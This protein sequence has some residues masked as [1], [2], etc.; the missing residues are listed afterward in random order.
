MPPLRGQMRTLSRLMR[1]PVWLFTLPA[2][3]SAAA[4]ASALPAGLSALL[5]PAG[6]L[7]P[8]CAV[9]CAVLSAITST[10]T[11]PLRLLS[12]LPCVAC[13][14][15]CALPVVSF[16]ILSPLPFLPPF[17]G[18]LCVFCFVACYGIISL[19]AGRL[20]CDLCL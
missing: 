5:S 12:A 2:M 20:P 8:A 1:P 15:V 7:S 4:S 19:Y 18:G 10:L 13:V 3:A 9:G 11:T 6:L 16:F 14:F 17:L